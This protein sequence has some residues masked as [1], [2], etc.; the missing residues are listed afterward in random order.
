MWGRSDDEIDGFIGNITKPRQAIA[1]V[2][3]TPLRAVRSRILREHLGAGRFT[4]AFLP[5][6]VL[7]RCLTG[8]NHFFSFTS[9]H[10]AQQSL[11]R[12]VSL[13]SRH[14]RRKSRVCQQ[15]QRLWGV[16]ASDIIEALCPRSTQSSIV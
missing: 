10:L 4:Q 14:C 6:L 7:L 8:S 15:P 11:R 16:L 2:G 9:M 5:K 12:F 3:R 1:L 13:L